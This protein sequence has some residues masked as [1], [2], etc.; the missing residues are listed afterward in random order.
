MEEDGW[1]MDWRVGF[2]WLE[3]CME[4]ELEL[5]NGGSLLLRFVVSWSNTFLS[6]I[7]DYCHPTFVIPVE[8]VWI[9]PVFSTCSLLVLLP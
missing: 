8:Y 4:L 6:Y 2:G 3:E 9:P 5:D 1:R 7:V